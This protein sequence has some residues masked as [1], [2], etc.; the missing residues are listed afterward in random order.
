MSNVCLCKGIS[1]EK[2]VEA[3]KNGAL[4]FEEVGEK[5]GAGTGPCCGAR[6]K[7]KIEELIE[8]NK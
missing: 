3:V 5:T 2:I 1:E 6:C 7:C 4:S 8:E